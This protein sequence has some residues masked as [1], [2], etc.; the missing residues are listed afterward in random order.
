MSVP[1]QPPNRTHPEPLVR[2]DADLRCT[3]SERFYRALDPAHR[4]QA[5]A[6][7][8]S[9]GHYSR[10]DQPTL[11]F[12]SSPQGV[13]AAMAAHGGTRGDLEVMDF[14]VHAHDVVDLRDPAAVRVAGVNL[15]DAVGPWQG[16]VASGGTP[17]SWAVRRRLEEIGAHGMIDPS[18]TRPGLWHLVLFTWN[19]PHGAH[20]EAAGTP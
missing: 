19:T 14:E 5:L 7:S 20:V 12:S 6:G 13:Q 1:G 2:A 9:A 16:V 15:A 4:D 17:S 11:Y 10:A 8:R 3:V 18:R